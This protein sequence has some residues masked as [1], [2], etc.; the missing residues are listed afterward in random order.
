MATMSV[1]SKLRL[2][3]EQG[4]V[5]TAHPSARYLKETVRALPWQSAVQRALGARTH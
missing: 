1:I 3:G 4:A 5:L 2:V